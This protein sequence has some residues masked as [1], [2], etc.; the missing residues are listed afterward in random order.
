MSVYDQDL[1]GGDADKYTYDYSATLD[2]IVGQTC[3]YTFTVTNRDGLVNQ[4]SSTVT[5]TQ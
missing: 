2:T 1:T 5:I 3:K 4:V